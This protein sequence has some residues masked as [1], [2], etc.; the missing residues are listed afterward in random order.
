MHLPDDTNILFLKLIYKPSQQSIMNLDF[1][2]V[3]EDSHEIIQHSN[4]S[5][6]HFYGVLGCFL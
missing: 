5:T 2:F 3:T 6:S 1:F 4:S